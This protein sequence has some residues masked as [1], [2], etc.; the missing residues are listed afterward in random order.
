M[1][2]LIE[3]SSTKKYTK[4]LAEKALNGSRTQNLLSEQ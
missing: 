3:D 2:D 1:K 4:D